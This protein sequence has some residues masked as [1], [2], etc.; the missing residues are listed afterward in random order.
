MYSTGGSSANK[1]SASSISL[2][3]SAAQSISKSGTFTPFRAFKLP[4]RITFTFS[5]VSESF[6][7]TTTSIKP[8]SMSNVMPGVHPR[9]SAFC[10]VVGFMVM[11]PGLILSLSSLQMPN[12]RMS[13]ATRGTGSPAS[14]AT[15]NLG[16]CKSP[17]TSTFLP[18]SD[19]NFRING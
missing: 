12:S 6:S 19:A 1:Y 10:S 7:V 8:S 15:R 14:S 16:P 3:V 17:R 18:I 2:E 4:P 11:R 13:P 9:T 5:S